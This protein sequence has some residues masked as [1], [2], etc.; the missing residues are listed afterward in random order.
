MA[1]AAS[2]PA[3]QPDRRPDG[4]AAATF[5]ATL[6]DEWVRAGC[7]DAVVAPGSRS[8]PLALAL[9][10]D[11]RLRV[12][13]FHDERAAGFAAL[14]L[15]LASGHPAPV[16]CTSG[17]AATHLHGAV[18]EASLS[19]VPMLVCTADRPP[20]LWQVG[21]PQTIDQ[22]ALYGSA[23]RFFAQPGVPDPAAAPS[24]RSV[25]SRAVAEACGS[26][27][28]PGPVHLNLSF[29][30]PLVA[31]AGPLP[32]GRPD[33]RPW[34]WTGPSPG[35]MGPDDG[36]AA[37]GVLEPVARLVAGR[38]GVIVAGAGIA[39]PAGVALLAARAGWPVLADHR[40][41]CRDLPPAVGHADPLLRHPRWAEGQ[42]PEVVLRLGQP[43]ASKV[44]GQWLASSGAVQVAVDRYGSW[45]D[46]D[47]SAEV[48]V[49]AEPGRFARLLA[50]LVPAG[51]GDD[52]ERW[53]SADAAA[54]AA[55]E[56]ELAAADEVS[57][58]STVRAA[59]AATPPAGALV[60]ASSMP[61]RDLEWFGGPPPPD[62]VVHANR[63]ANGIDG[64]VSTAVG[65]A[66]TGRSTVCVVGDVAFL[67][68]ATALVG[69]ADRRV[70]LT[71]VV[72]DND[73]GG[74][75]SFLPQ[76]SQVQPDRFERLFGTPH[77]TDLVAVA[78][79]HRLPAVDPTAKG[80]VGVADAIATG[81][82]SGVANVVVVRT[83]RTANV[84]LHRR[85]DRA[86]GASLG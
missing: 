22:T 8:T 82:A 64:V 74:I 46:P 14:G 80:P 4:S 86:V 29:R 12:H 23:V 39:D 57:E 79:A 10:G 68:D 67:H 78:G 34:H 55:I 54:A 60:V 2:S 51:A 81:V 7:T 37:D 30:D 49:R 32:P 83:E 59:L 71:V 15:A 6:V 11:P 50:A 1:S 69:L 27:G 28:R 52:L 36:A 21:A 47:R 75:F 18:V 73:G 5:C 72:L 56:A 85:L 35:G 70:A 24:W 63:G 48:V 38:R 44:L 13:V 58:P 66:L 84:A 65:V 77:G 41:G 61:V 26:G 42:R 16:L 33:G 25:G 76:A 3:D 43:L 19:D 20:E 31:A 53:R 45:R 9:V 17:T 40:S 62:V